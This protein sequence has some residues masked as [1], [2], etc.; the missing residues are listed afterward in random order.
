ML[1]RTQDEMAIY[2]LEKMSSIYVTKDDED[3]YTV[4]CLGYTG[5]LAYPIGKYK[6]EER[7][8]AIIEEIYALCNSASRYDMPIV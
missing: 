5:E 8:R 4:Y 3:T 1:I 7:A 6:K 2:D